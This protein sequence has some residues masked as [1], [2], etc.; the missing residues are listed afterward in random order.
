M[1]YQ[2]IIVAAGNSSRSNLSYNK[3]FYKIDNNPIIL[4]ST[5]HFINDENCEK[6]FIVCKKIELELFNEIFLDNKKIFYVEGGNTR[7]ESVN[8]ALKYVDS[9]YVL[10]HDGAR[11]FVSKKLINNVLINL[12][13]NDAVIP[14]IFVTDTVKIV[15]DNYVVKTL[16]REELRNVQTPQGFKTS[17]IKKA[18]EMAKTNMFTDDSSMVE[19][20]LNCK[21]YA[22][23]GE[24]SNIKFTIKDDFKKEN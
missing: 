2:T 18:H 8:N 15:R 22:I 17:I 4:L 10:I 14:T 16:K 6:I 21:V 13:T 24:F 9:D 7:Q 11:P 19:E 3:V 5:R 20:I 1:K 23:D 12:N